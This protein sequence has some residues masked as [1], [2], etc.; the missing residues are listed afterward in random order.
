MN[1][2]P[3]VWEGNAVSVDGHV[4]PLASAASSARQVTVGV[5][6]GDLRIAD[7][8][9]PARVERVE[10]L[11]DSAIVSFV[12][13]RAHPQAGRPIACRD[14]QGRR[15]ASTLRSHREAA[16]IFDRQQG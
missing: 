13:R 1:L 8:G 3:G 16:H 2:L 6:P 15:S 9:L 12:R 10:D 14:A 4:L 7:A 11:G 5:R